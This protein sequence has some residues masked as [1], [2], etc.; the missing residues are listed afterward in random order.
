MS[1][2]ISTSEQ[3]GVAADGCSWSRFAQIFAATAI[4]LF[5][6]LCAVL[7]LVDPF[8]TGRSPLSLKKGFPAP[9][10]Q[11]PMTSRL[12]NASRGRDETFDAAIIG[13]S[14]VQA[15]EPERLTA[16]TGTSFVALVVQA[17]GPRELFALW[18]WFVAHRAS[19]AKAIVLGID[20][21]WCAAGPLTTN[22]PFPFWL[23]DPSRLAYLK[24]LLRYDV[25]VRDL[26]ERIAYL[27]G[28]RERARP[29][30]YWD[31]EPTFTRLGFDGEEKRRA[32]EGPKLTT[33]INLTG[34][35]RAADALA[36]RLARL[37]PQTRVVLLR[38][39]VFVTG[40]PSPGSGAA[41]SDRACL[42]TFQAVAAARPNTVVLDWRAH[43]PELRDAAAFIDHTHY[44]KKLARLVEADIAREITGGRGPSG[45]TTISLD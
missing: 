12:G 32:L 30:G 16:A 29:D 10:F 38:P 8:D 17:S 31:Y 33:D 2:S 1:S 18:D 35:F 41:V 42:A 4:S 24:G 9:D 36:E 44:R 43:R 13:N 15:L 40:L 22:E 23:Y 27:F 26:P 45:N 39:P 25:V 20:G 6:A 3:G 14:H 21:P 11:S 7:Y 28:L 19:P 34:T 5:V 37:P